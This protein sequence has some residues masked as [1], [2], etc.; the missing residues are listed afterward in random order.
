MAWGQIII[1]FILGAFLGP[2]LLAKV[3]GRS[4]SATTG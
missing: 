4:R 1:A 2:M 3:T